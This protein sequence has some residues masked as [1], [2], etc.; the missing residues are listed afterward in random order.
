MRGGYGAV[1][2]LFSDGHV[3]VAGTRSLPK[4]K[5]QG[6]CCHSDVG[7]RRHPAAC[8]QLPHSSLGAGGGSAQ[9]GG[10][11]PFHVPVA[12]R[13]GPRGTMTKASWW[14]VYRASSLTR[15]RPPLEP[16]RRPMPR[17]LGGS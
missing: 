15:K 6:E 17:V 11:L 1:A 12:R 16:Y 7:H 5:T 10:A 8:G 4:P 3:A 9:A 14:R 13:Q 2:S